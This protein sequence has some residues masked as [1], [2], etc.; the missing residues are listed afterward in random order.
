VVER[1]FLEDGPLIRPERDP[2]GLQRLSRSGV[3]Q[4]LRPLAANT[5]ER[6]VDCPDD[7]GERDLSC[8]TGEPEAAVRAALAAYQA[9]APQLGEDSL[10]ELPRNGL[11]PGK[12]VRRHMTAAGGSELDNGAQSI[13]GTRGQTHMQHY[14]Q[15]RDC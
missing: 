13:I 7:V 14:P 11:R 5:H 12:L 4:I 8:R 6:A 15:S 10:Q 1:D 9:S 3:A 2:D